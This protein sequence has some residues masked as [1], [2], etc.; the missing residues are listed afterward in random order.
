MLQ[1]RFRR[2]QH[3]G[4]DRAEKHLAHDQDGRIGFDGDGADRDQIGGEDHIKQHQIQHMDIPESGNALVR[5]QQH[6]GQRHRGSQQREAVVFLFQEDHRKRRYEN[7]VHADHAGDHGFPHAGRTQQQK[8]VHDHQ[9]R[10]QDDALQNL[11]AVQ[12]EQFAPEQRQCNQKTDQVGD[13]QKRERGDRRWNAGQKNILDRGEECDDE[14]R[15]VCFQLIHGGLPA[16]NTSAAEN[17]ACR[18]ASPCAVR[19]R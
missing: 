12:A 17:P 7:E 19:P 16:D 1:E 11:L 14:Q 15:D 6:A 18:T 13:R 8:D 2:P 10:G 4:E 3:Q 5:D 9:F